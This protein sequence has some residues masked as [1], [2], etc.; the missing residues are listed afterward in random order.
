MLINKDRD[1]W[2]LVLSP[3]E[4]LTLDAAK[5]IAQDISSAELPNGVPA[6][7]DVGTTANVVADAIEA[8]ELAL[9]KANQLRLQAN[10]PRLA[11]VV[12]QDES[13]AD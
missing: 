9:V 1:G 2:Y 10:R 13:D 6:A 4:L 11:P 7:P 8:F 12:T 5:K 3:H